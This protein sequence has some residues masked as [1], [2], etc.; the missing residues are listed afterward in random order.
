VGAKWST[1][2]ADYLAVADIWLNPG[3][4][5][6]AVTD[7][8]AVGLPLATTD[9][10][11]HGPEIAYLEHTKT[12]LITETDVDN[13]ASEVFRVLTEDNLL[14]RAKSAAAEEG[15]K[16]S[17]ESMAARFA[18]GIESCLAADKATIGFRCRKEAMP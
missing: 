17:V 12:G 8:F 14:P 5:G 18:D 2:R 7:A 13:Y 15:R 6:L 1:E 16:Y 10:R 11:T 9:N 3:A 4:V